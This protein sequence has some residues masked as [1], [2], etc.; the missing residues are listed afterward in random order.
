MGR[1]VQQKMR[2]EGEQRGRRKV[3]RAP[4][5]MSPVIHLVILHGAKQLVNQVLNSVNPDSPLV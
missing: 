3:G 4:R 5:E 2:D 1:V